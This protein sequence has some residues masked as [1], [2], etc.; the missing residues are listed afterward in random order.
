MLRRQVTRYLIVGSLG[1]AAHLLVLML[2]VEHLLMDVVRASIAGFLSALSVSYV[3]N[4]YWTFASERTH[5]DSLWRYFVVSVFGL[6]LNTFMVYVMVEFLHWWYLSSQLAVIFVV[7]AISFL[8]N[9][10]WAFASKSN[11]RA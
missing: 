3:L 10:Y 4:H 8:L 1:T 6:L 11:L 7:P 5:L 9:R 2:C